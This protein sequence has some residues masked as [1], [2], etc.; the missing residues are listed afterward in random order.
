MGH[1]SPL[2]GEQKL[3]VFESDFHSY[4]L[5]FIRLGIERYFQTGAHALA[6]AQMGVADLI[7]LLGPSVR[8][9]LVVVGVLRNS[10]AVRFFSETGIPCLNL[11]EFGRDPLVPFDVRIEGEG[12]LAAKYFIEE[13]RYSNLGF[14]GHTHAVSHQRRFREF[15]GESDRRRI[16][17]DTMW[18]ATSRTQPHFWD[19]PIHEWTRRKDAL[20]SF[21]ERLPKPAG[22]FC[23]DDGIALRV[24]Y[25][26][27]MMGIR[28]PEELAILGVGSRDQ[29]KL[30]WAHV[31]SVV[32][33][34]HQNLGYTAAR[35]MDEFVGSQRTP[36][37]VRL[38]PSGICHCQTTL[39][40]S[41]ADPLV[42]R[43]LMR[44]QDS[45]AIDVATLSEELQ[46]SRAALDLR[47]RRI[48]NMTV[49]K[50]I[51]V[52][53]FSLAKDLIRRRGYSLETVASLAGYPNRRG[54]R[55]S[56]Y[57]FTRMSPQQFRELGGP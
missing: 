37:P 24:F 17:V 14:I 38:D 9:R 5:A 2:E 15:S 48:T 12:A 20:R 43:A 52:E 31:V 29:A 46:V 50:A 39:R 27:E 13:G 41:V 34:D 32:T 26:A 4:H 54:M 23:A 11:V 51:E 47:F 33:L 36:E 7:E 30:E 55:R 3:L 35:L 22:V 42:S 28:V 25:T 53:R 1:C 18:I 19:I 45:P 6:F 8:D 10:E 16:K 56:F 21:L 57:R 44:I 49:A 40:R